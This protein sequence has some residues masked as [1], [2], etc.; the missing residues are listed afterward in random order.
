MGEFGIGCFDREQS[1]IVIG[2]NSGHFGGISFTIGGVDYEGVTHRGHLAPLG[3]NGRVLSASGQDDGAVANSVVP[4]A[5]GDRA[6]CRG[7][8]G[9]FGGREEAQGLIV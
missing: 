4:V 9:R 8:S 2:V 6:F 3:Q 5:D 1:E 7:S